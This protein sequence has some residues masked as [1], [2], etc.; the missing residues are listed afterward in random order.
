MLNARAGKHPRIEV[1][2]LGMANYFTEGEKL[3]LEYYAGRFS[4]DLVL[5]GFLRN[6][7]IQTAQGMDAYKV[8]D[9]G[10]LLTREAALLGRAGRWFYFHSHACRIMLRKYIDLVIAK[11]YPMDWRGLCQ[12]DGMHES[13][14]LKVE[15]ELKEI[16]DIARG[17]KAR[18][19]V[20]HIPEPNYQYC[21]YASERLSVWCARYGIDFIDTLPLFFDAQQQGD[22]FW[23][24]DPHLTPYGY[25][26]L[27]IAVSGYLADKQ[28]VP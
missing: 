7:V 4:P 24:S 10:Y 12:S 3:A 26:V 22:I 1:I 23:R 15:Q 9:D 14:W 18:M 13:D 2:N 6:D 16:D 27:A 11:K 8:S 25:R 17:Y 19:A 21:P 20:V 5:V 28:L